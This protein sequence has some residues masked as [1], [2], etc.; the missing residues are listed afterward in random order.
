MVSVV[1]R[2]GKNAF[3][4]VI[5]ATELHYFSLLWYSTPNIYFYYDSIN[6]YFLQKQTKKP[7][8]ITP[9]VWL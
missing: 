3:A 9:L 8:K 5:T 1:N 7:S 4:Q 6:L 2:C